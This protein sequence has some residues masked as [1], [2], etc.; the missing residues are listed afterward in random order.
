MMPLVFQG[1]CEQV[2]WQ[3]NLHAHA[4]DPVNFE[5]IQCPTTDI[6]LA[7]SPA[8]ACWSSGIGRPKLVFK[9]VYFLTWLHQ[10]SEVSL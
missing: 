9:P 5:P 4:V 6:Y 8:C 3:E 1:T 2:K 7:F 10:M